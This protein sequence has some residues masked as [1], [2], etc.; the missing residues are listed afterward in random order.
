MT[1]VLILCTHNSARSQMAEALTRDAAQRLSLRAYPE[2]SL[3][4]ATGASLRQMMRQAANST[5][6]R[7]RS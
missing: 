5:N 3:A 6:P 2:S 4:G 1:R 7:Y